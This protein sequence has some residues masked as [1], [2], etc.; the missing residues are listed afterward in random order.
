MV[1]VSLFYN[2]AAIQIDAQAHFSAS[3][4]KGKVKLMLQ[5]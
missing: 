4:S 3:P 1:A 5:K 2:S